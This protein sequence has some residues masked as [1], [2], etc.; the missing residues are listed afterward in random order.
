MTKSAELYRRF[1]IISIIIIVSN[2][3]TNQSIRESR[4]FPRERETKRPIDRSREGEEEVSLEIGDYR[5]S[6]VVAV[7]L[8]L[9]SLIIM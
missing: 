1:I 7:C 9:R 3:E 2:C 6:S 5:C 8:L 4:I